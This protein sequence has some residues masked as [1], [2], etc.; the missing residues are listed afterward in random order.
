MENSKKFETTIDGRKVIVEVG[1]LCAL[2]NGSCTVTCGETVVMANVTIAAKAR[3]GLDYFPLS[4]DFEEKMYSV[5]KIPGGFRKREGRAGDKA[6]LTAR[7][8][9]RPLRPLFPKGIF[10]DVALVVTT[11][12]VDPEVDP[13]PYAMLASSIAL[14]ISDIPWNGPT[15]SYLI[16]NDKLHLVVS[17]T[18][19]AVLMVE[20]GA[21]QVSEAEMLSEIMR[22]HT[23]IKKQVEFINTIVKKVGKEKMVFKPKAIDEALEKNVRAYVTSYIEKAMAETDLEK[24]REKEDRVDELVADKFAEIWDESGK[25]IKEIMYNVKKEIVRDK[26]LTSGRRPDGRGTKDIRP[27]WTDVGVLP[28]VHGSAVFTR[29]STQVLNV[30]TLG[31]IADAQKIDDI[32]D[33]E[34]KRYMHHYNMPPYSV[35]EARPMRAPGRREVGHGALAERALEPVLP[36]END[37]PYA[38]RTVSE[39]LSSNGS[40]SMASVCGSSMSL[41]NAGVPI[42]SAVAGIAMGLIKDKHTGKVAVLSDILGMED[43]LGDMDFK[44][45]GTSKGITAIQMDMKIAGIDENIIKTA[46]KQAQDGRMHILKKMEDSIKKPASEL[47]KYAPKIISFKIHPDKIREVIGT[48]GK[49]INKIIDETGVKIDIEDDGT[50][51]IGGTDQAMLDKAKSIIDGICFEPE[52]GAVITGDVKKILPIGAI[53]E[54][55]SKSGLIHISKLSKERVA[56]VE[57]VLN[58]GD[59][60]KAEI[61]KIS[62]KGVDLKLIEKK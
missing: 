42:S 44:V 32:T 43:F 16:S 15:G 21:N 18:A 57:D 11:L 2:S 45:A 47:S 58:L 24:R 6:I 53:I 23:E 40:S 37:F 20:A 9:D 50:V 46:L 59:T 41:M 25:D 31:M 38:I 49:V 60:V 39:V 13:A 29:G 34:Y 4:V 17:G 48:G 5:G 22:A 30:C 26:I 35:G 62:E 12:S 51:R 1:A 10:N 61:I 27:I 7:L 3:E 28:R 56:K 19:D 36:T 33:E 54:F 55:G 8:I 14:A 52:V